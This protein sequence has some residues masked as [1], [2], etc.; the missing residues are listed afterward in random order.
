MASLDKISVRDEVSRLKADFD[1]LG[2]EGKL[3]SESQAIMNSLFMIVELILAIFLERNTK[4]DSNNSSKP[5]SQTSKDESVLSHPGNNGKGKSE[6]KDQASNSRVNETVT[7]SLA[8][9]CEVCAQDLSEVP[10]ID[11]ERRSGI[12]MVVEKA[13]DHVDAE[14]KYCPA[15]GV[16]VKGV[17]PPSMHGSLQ[18]DDGLKAFVINLLIGQYHPPSDLLIDI[19]PLFRRAR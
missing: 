4:K 7:I 12:E 15:C 1:R 19:W 14:I 2:A 11:H 3:S 10:C 5:S 13:I 8:L 18:Y 6:N 16:T 17:F 9:T